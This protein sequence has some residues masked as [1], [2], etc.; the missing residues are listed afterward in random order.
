MTSFVHASHSF[1][2]AGAERAANAV[3]GIQSLF[4]GRRG[5]GAM[6][7]AAVVSAVL[8]AANQLIDTWSDQH[9][10]GA[11]VTLW[12]IAFTA[13]ALFSAPLRRLAIRMRVAG[14]ARRE[15]SKTAAEDRKLWDLAMSDARVMADINRAMTISARE[16]RRA[17]WR[18]L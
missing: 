12:A 5:T 11:W 16:E 15:R 14:A 10:F 7:L 9:V 17:A 13:L 3:D 18:V 8:V 2:H 6:L 1:E 4:D